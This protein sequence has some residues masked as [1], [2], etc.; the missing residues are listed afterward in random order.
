[1]CKNCY[2]LIQINIGKN[3][4]VIGDECFMGCSNIEKVDNHYQSQVQIIGKRAFANCKAL[5]TIY[6]L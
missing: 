6:I 4:L 5:D 3:V 2:N 1:M